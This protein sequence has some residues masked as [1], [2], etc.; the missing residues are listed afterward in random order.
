M[1]SGPGQLHQIS[2]PYNELIMNKLIYNLLFSFLS[3][4]GGLCLASMKSM[5]LP[6]RIE[7]PS[8]W[9]ILICI[10]SVVVTVFLMLK[11]KYKQRVPSE[12]QG[13]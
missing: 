4:F 2:Y 13:Y 1:K 7:I 9:F 11:E 10:S 8:S 12:E 3:L 6:I 5:S